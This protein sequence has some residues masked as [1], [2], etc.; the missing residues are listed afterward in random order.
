MPKGRAENCGAITTNKS[1]WM[2][3]NCELDG[4]SSVVYGTISWFQVLTHFIYTHV[5]V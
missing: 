1:E 4:T 2:A 3:T 5:L